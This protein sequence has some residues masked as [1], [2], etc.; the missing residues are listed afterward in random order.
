MGRVI[1]DYPLDRS[2][3]H[4]LDPGACPELRKAV[5]E[6]IRLLGMT[7]G[8]R[9]VDGSAV[10]CSGSVAGYRIVLFAPSN[11]CERRPSAWFSSNTDSIGMQDDPNKAASLFHE[12][13]H[14]SDYTLSLNRSCFM[15][16]M[17]AME[18]FASEEK[19]SGPTGIVMSAISPLIV[20]LDGQRTRTYINMREMELRLSGLSG[21]EIDK[22]KE[23]LF[24]EA[25]QS[26]LARSRRCPV[27]SWARFA[28][29]ASAYLAMASDLQAPITWAKEDEKWDHPDIWHV[30]KHEGWPPDLYRNTEW[31]KWSINP[32]DVA[33]G[34]HQRALSAALDLFV[35]VLVFESVITVA[36]SASYQW[37]GIEQTGFDQIYGN[38]NLEAAKRYLDMGWLESELRKAV[39]AG[40][41][42][43]QE[44]ARDALEIFEQAPDKFD[45]IS[46]SKELLR[47]KIPDLLPETGEELSVYKSRSAMSTKH[48]ASLFGVSASTVSKAERSGNELLKG[49]LWKNM[50][51]L[52]GIE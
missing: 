7:I 5:E 36:S 40:C 18:C 2:E 48:M 6:Q 13:W 31:S 50:L 19:D 1:G 22:E 52:H 51:A 47:R 46:M 21:R 34:M 43:L 28:S 42:A 49:K 15:D 29:E 44:H 26:E 3:I 27:E 38:W 41:I 39:D 32:T 16:E 4:D 12:L 24:Q 14:M 17:E 25:F 37:G 20:N 30:Q 10:M 35:G 33:E 45:T 9:L 11:E 8:P 23:R